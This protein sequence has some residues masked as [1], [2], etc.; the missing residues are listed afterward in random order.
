[1]RRID[2]DVIEYFKTSRSAA[3]GDPLSRRHTHRTLIEP[4]LPIVR[5]HCSPT[6]SH[7]RFAISLN[8][9]GETPLAGLGTFTASQS[10]SINAWMWGCRPFPF[11]VISI[12]ATPPATQRFHHRSRRSFVNPLLISRTP[13]TLD[14]DE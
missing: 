7:A 4:G 3:V 10:E 1:M 13:T 8:R 6:S 14:R 9:L 2:S 11:E 12:P 5:D